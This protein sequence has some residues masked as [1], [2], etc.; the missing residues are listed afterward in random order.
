MEIN[1]IIPAAG[2]SS[3]YN[4][5]K[6]KW[7]RT[8]PDGKLMIE[9][10]TKPFWSN[11]NTNIK[12][13]IYIICTQEIVLKY[14]VAN[15]LKDT[16][17]LSS[18]TLVSLKKQTSSA[19]ETILEGIKMLNGTIEPQ[20]PTIVKDA[21]NYVDF[22]LNSLEW[23]EN[24]SVGCPLKK[25]SVSAVQNKSFLIIN[26]FNEI[27][28]YIEK[29]VV[30]DIIGVGTHGFKTL[31]DFI[32]NS[33][34]LLGAGLKG[35]LY[36]SHV[37]QNMIINDNNTF[38]YIEAIDYS[39]YGTQKEWNKIFLSATSYFVDFDG[40][41]V[42]NKGKYGS[43]NWSALKDVPI[44]SNISIIKKLQ[45]QGA[46][47]V[48]TTSRTSEFKNYI[49]GFLQELGIKPSNI[50]CDLPHSPRVLINDFANT[51]PYPSCK[52]ISLP[53]NGDLSQYFQYD[54][55]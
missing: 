16:S 14:D 4:E 48:I 31:T 13:N 23:G 2:R 20:L 17:A 35:E 26:D 46:Q 10:A 47:I 38:N 6:P 41:L 54:L 5:G 3:R 21:D 9:H 50:I 53:R 51:N 32:E 27:T 44:D 33:S 49:S 40:T 18:S 28:D 12:T 34:K 1:V 24:F 42:L 15:I 19:V 45:E 37:I 43:N 52:A 30:S 39:D 8:H 29:R 55:E 11:N 7:L 25:F 22:D 36:V